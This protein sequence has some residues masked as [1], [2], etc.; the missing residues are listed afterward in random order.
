MS[1]ATSNF[2]MAKGRN[3]ASAITK[4]RFVK[5]VADDTDSVEQCDTAGEDAYGAA[6][7]SVSDA[8]IAAGKLV[9]VHTDGRAILEAGEAIDAGQ[10]VATDN[11]GKA[12]VATSGD[13]ILGMCDE[14]CDGD[15]D[16][17]SVDMSKRGGVAA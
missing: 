7:F 1:P 2:T 3:A 11:A 17:V 5:M 16:E 6:L 15:G 9:S 4:K 14:P 10:P 8:E 12:V 13:I